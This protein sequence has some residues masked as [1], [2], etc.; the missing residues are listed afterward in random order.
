MGCTVISNSKSSLVAMEGSG[1]S[2]LDKECDILAT[3]YPFPLIIRTAG[4]AGTYPLGAGQSGTTNITLENGYV[5]S[6]AWNGM[7]VGSHDKDG[8]KMSR[9]SLYRNPLGLDRE[10]PDICADGEDIYVLGRRAGNGTS[11]STPAVAGIAALVQGCWTGL[12]NLPE[13]CRAIL[14]TSAARRA[15]PWNG[16][17]QET[18]QL[19]N[20]DGTP[21][22]RRKDIAGGAGIVDAEAACRIARNIWR[23]VIVQSERGWT[24]GELERSM[25]DP[26]SRASRTHWKIKAPEKR[27]ASPIIVRAALVFSTL[28]EEEFADLDPEYDLRIDDDETL[29]VVTYSASFYSSFEIVEFTA[30]PNHVYRIY[31]THHTGHHPPGTDK[32]TRFGLAWA[33]FIDDRCC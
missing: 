15:E 19:T 14:Y 2:S 8:W 13:A 1:F 4:N 17:W 31:I 21:N 26:T 9:F 6:K 11:F 10:L 33:C 22:P 7:C 18:I 29:S 5:S 28:V 23:I 24:Y 20:D 25:F 27:N 16:T 32:K 3:K 30:K 12:E